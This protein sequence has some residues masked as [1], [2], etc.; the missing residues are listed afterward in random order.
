MKKL[1]TCTLLAVCTIC[2]SQN[3]LS[4]KGIEI[5]GTLT[6][7]SQKLEASGYKKIYTND[8]QD[9]CV[10]EGA[11]AG[12]DQCMI[13]VIST[14]QEHIVWKVAVQLPEQSSWYS[15]K[16]RYNEFRESLMEK[17]GAPSKKYE[18][19]SSPYYEGDG[20]EMSALNNEKCH[21]LLSSKQ[22]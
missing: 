11:F 12:Y 2:F 1:I 18:F 21:M 15:L 16:S 10:L 14:A 8:A 9:A 3:H 6:D 5:N 20:Y 4:F 19:F 7:F 17:Y 22:I 13:F